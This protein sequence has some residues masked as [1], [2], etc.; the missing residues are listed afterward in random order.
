MGRNEGEGSGGVRGQGQGGAKDQ[1]GARGVGV[2]AGQ[3]RARGLGRG[4]ETR[5]S[6]CRSGKPGGQGKAFVVAFREF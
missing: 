4:Q 2:R 3:G 1:G 5:H 6:Q